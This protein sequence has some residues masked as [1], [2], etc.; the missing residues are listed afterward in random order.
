MIVFHFAMC[1][2]RGGEKNVWISV[3]LQS[4]AVKTTKAWRSW[5]SQTLHPTGSDAAHCSGTVPGGK[6]QTQRRNQ[7]NRLHGTGELFFC[8]LVFCC[9][10]WFAE[11]FA[12]LNLVKG[13]FKFL[14]E[15]ASMVLLGTIACP[16]PT[17]AL[18]SRWFFWTSQGEICDRFLDGVLSAS[19]ITFTSVKASLNET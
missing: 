10:C 8:F 2:F 15:K 1:F 19:F 4:Q 16:L 17:K 13:D 5:V 9:S 6:K 14:S 18:L 11:M 7:G 3:A 12:G